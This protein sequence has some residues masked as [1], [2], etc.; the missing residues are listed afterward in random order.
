MA[1]IPI[2]LFLPNAGL[3]N[4]GGTQATATNVVAAAPAEE[5]I[6]RAVVVTGASNVTVRS[7]ANPPALEGGQ[8]DLIVNCPI[9]TTWIGPLTSGRFVQNGGAFNVDAATPANV[10]LTAFRVP[11]SA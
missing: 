10:T 5:L 4:P 3:A 2:T 11:R 1:A 6:L 7:G 8:G 9:G